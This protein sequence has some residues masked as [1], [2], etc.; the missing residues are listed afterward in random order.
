MFLSGRIP[1]GFAVVYNKD[2]R[3]MSFDFEICGGCARYNG[4]KHM[5]HLSTWVILYAKIMDK[6]HI[7]L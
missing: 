3:C 6:V 7:V 4:K 2:F 5:K 1:E